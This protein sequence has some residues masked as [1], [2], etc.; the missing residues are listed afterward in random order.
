MLDKTTIIAPSIINIGQDPMVV[1]QAELSFPDV[2]KWISYMGPGTWPTGTL[3]CTGY[4]R[5]DANFIGGLQ[6]MF[7]MIGQSWARPPELMQA[8]QTAVDSPTIDVKLM[9]NVTD[10]MT[11]DALLIPVCESGSITVTQPYAMVGFDE[12]SFSQFWNSED[13]WL[14]K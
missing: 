11:K 9:R 10:M 14:N 5:F 7:G 3:L 1:I 6:F 4:P 2:G 8:L 13:F 12:R